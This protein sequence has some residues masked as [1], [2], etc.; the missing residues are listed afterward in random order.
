MQRQL[1]FRGSE[2]TVSLLSKIGS[3]IARSVSRFLPR[4]RLILDKE[5]ILGNFSAQL[6][7]IRTNINKEEISREYVLKREGQG[8]TFLD[9]GARDGE[10]TYLLG[11]RGNLNFDEDFYR[12]NLASFRTKYKYFGMDILPAADS[13]VI[14][15]DACELGYAEQHESFREFFDVI[16]SNN[17]FEHFERPWVAAQNLTKLL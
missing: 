12:Q 2:M 3:K 1:K 10:L 8:M 9:V 6:I 13:R 5:R 15:G 7:G 16:Y 17:V 14:S 4:F 11:I